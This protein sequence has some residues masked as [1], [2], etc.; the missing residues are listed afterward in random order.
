VRGTGD[1]ATSGACAKVVR[2]ARS[3]KWFR[4][5]LPTVS[6]NTA[7]GTARLNQTLMRF[8]ALMAPSGLKS[9][10]VCQAFSGCVSTS[11]ACR[12]S[13]AIRAF[14]MTAKHSVFRF[15]LRGSRLKVR[16]IGV[17]FTGI[18]QQEF[19]RSPGLVAAERSRP[20]RRSRRHR[21]LVAGRHVG[22]RRQGRR[23]HL[24]WLRVTIAPGTSAP[25]TATMFGPFSWERVR[26]PLQ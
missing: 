3:R 14:R 13:C 2:V 22:P 17:R 15:A 4:Q 6:Y 8:P 16:M 21:D 23:A 25:A 20:A 9:A 26:T 12:R 5:R 18:L 10:F 24:E 11:M 1:V 19:V 7:F